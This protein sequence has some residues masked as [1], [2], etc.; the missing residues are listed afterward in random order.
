MQTKG[1]AL[2]RVLIPVV[3][4]AKRQL[5]WGVACCPMGA[6]ATVHFFVV[7]FR[8]LRLSNLS[9]SYIRACSLVCVMVLQFVHVTKSSLCA[10]FGGCSVEVCMALSA[11][12]RL[13][14]TA[15]MPLKLPGVGWRSDSKWNADLRLL[16]QR[17]MI[18]QANGKKTDQLP[19]D[20]V[21][22]VAAYSPASNDKTAN[23]ASTSISM[24]TPTQ[25]PEKPK[26]QVRS[27]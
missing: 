11:T 22:G 4:A 25:I 6:V 13:S 27:P 24:D 26:P 9:Y 7:T 2:E 3:Y 17:F 15:L 21:P 18:G 20:H 16:Y 5:L 19:A 14:V 10:R 23:A 1:A 8:N 12:C